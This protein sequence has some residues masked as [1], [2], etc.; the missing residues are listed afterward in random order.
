MEENTSRLPGLVLTVVDGSIN[1]GRRV[2]FVRTS[3]NHQSF[4]TGNANNFLGGKLKK[5]FFGD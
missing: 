4:K 2:S 1:G 5:F 3:N